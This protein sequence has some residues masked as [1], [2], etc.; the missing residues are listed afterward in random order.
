MIFFNLLLEEGNDVLITEQVG[1]IIN[2][3][4]FTCHLITDKKKTE[5]AKE[6]SQTNYIS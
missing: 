4:P 3:P 6:K 1:P 5:K 2:Y